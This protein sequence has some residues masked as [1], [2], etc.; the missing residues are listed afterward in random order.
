MSKVHFWKAHRKDRWHIDSFFISL[1]MENHYNDVEGLLCAK[2][3]AQI[4]KCSRGN[5]ERLQLKGIL[6]PI[7]TIFPKYYY[8]K[9]E[10]IALKE[11][12][13]SKSN[14]I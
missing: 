9:L 4:L 14:K 13:T 7:P 11:K 1:T 2:E 10:V 6:T 3:V 12:L 8:S 5:I